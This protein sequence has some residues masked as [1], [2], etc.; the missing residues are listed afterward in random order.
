MTKDIKA[1]NQE[2]QNISKQIQRPIKK[3]PIHQY[4]NVKFT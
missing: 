3:R 2:E 1:Q 4:Q